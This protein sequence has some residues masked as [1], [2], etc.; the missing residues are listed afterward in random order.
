MLS[1]SYNIWSHSLKLI[2]GHNIHETMNP[3]LPLVSLATDIKQHQLSNLEYCLRDSH[4]FYMTA[5]DILVGRKL[6]HG[7]ARSDTRI[8]R[9]ILIFLMK[10]AVID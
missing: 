2:K 3:L 10:L 8:F 9:A 7:L 1:S 4:C 5:Q 6:L